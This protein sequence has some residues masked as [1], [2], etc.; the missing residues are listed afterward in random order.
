MRVSL[1]RRAKQNWK[2]KRSGKLK[3]DGYKG[4]RRRRRRR[5]KA[6]KNGRHEKKTK[7]KEN[8]SDYEKMQRE[9]EKPDAGKTAKKNS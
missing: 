1:T 7:Q 9:P 6:T 2:I 3:E 4:R 8:E 5:V